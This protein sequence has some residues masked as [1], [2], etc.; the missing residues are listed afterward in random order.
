MLKNLVT[1]LTH[2]NFFVWNRSAHRVNEMV[3][4]YAVG[5]IISCSSAREVVE[6]SDVI[7]CMLSTMDASEVVFDADDGV[8]AGVSNGKLIVDCAT[9]TP[10]RMLDE[11]K[12]VKENMKLSKKED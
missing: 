4:Q 10:E 9:L 8:I 1:K 3:A 12:R 7:F 6:K 11:A 2:A 5:K